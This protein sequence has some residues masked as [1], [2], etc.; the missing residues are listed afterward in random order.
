M[1]TAE[2]RNAAREAAT[3]LNWAEAARLMRHAI[4]VYP[5]MPSRAG[6]T[7]V[8]R[9][10]VARMTAAAESY[11]HAIARTNPCATALVAAAAAR[12]ARAL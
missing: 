12:Q 10:D 6:L 8:Q 5:V 2:A 7:E 3:Q 11:E 1:N 4:A 9:A